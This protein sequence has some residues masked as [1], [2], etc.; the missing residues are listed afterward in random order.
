M[1]ETLYYSPSPQDGP[2]G[3]LVKMLIS[4]DKV[5]FPWENAQKQMKVQ[6][7]EEGVMAEGPGPRNQN[8]SRMTVPYVG[9]FQSKCVLKLRCVLH[10]LNLGGTVLAQALHLCLVTLGNWNKTPRSSYKHSVDFASKP[11]LDSNVASI[12]H[13][14][15]DK[16][17]A[18]WF[19]MMPL[20]ESPNGLRN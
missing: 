1:A 16:T 13:I 5:P 11:L 18:W 6:I 15:D 14:L 19:P 7:P 10:G 12:L 17:K 4:E 9:F 8:I 2:T 3:T 20:C